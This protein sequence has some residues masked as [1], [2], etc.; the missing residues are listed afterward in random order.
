MYKDRLT[1]SILSLSLAIEV[2]HLYAETTF[3]VAGWV[4][5][6]RVRHLPLFHW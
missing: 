5:G 6:T 2:S 1:H 3:I 4:K